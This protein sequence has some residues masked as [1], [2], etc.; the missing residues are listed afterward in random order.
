VEFLAALSHQEIEIFQRQSTRPDQLGDLTGQVNYG[1]IYWVI[2]VCARFSL[3]C[4]ETLPGKRMQAIAAS[5][6]NLVSSN[7]VKYV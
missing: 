7:G 4:A 2:P 5:N 6:K 1:R 3:S